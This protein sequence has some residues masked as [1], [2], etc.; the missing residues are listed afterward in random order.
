[1][2]ISNVMI[3]WFEDLFHRGVFRDCASILDLGPQDLVTTDA[4]I[5]NFVSSVSGKSSSIEQ[6]RSSYFENGSVRPYAMRLFYAAMGLTQY[7]AVD[8]SDPRAS[9]RLDLNEQNNLGRTFDV[10]TNFGTAEHVFDISNVMRFM[11]DHLSPM[12]IALHVLPTRGD[13][14]HGFYNIH[15]TFYRDLA[16]A[17]GYQIVSLRNVPDFGGQHLKVSK[18][19]KFGDS[20]PRI[21]VLTDIVGADDEGREE[22]FAWTVATR[23]L[24]RRFVDKNADS[25]IY[26][27]IFAAL[28]KTSS[29]PFRQPQQ[30]YYSKC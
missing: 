6:I 25:R 7:D 29:A 5:G 9:I 11:H 30:G 16:A 27:Y 28:R 22:S 18:R 15:S 17:N 10:I 12:G 13:Y 1:M 19:E 3:H 24:Y 14:N 20:T 4:V 8:L 21:S 23:L 26:D 2:G